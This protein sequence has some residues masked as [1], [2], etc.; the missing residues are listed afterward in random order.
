MSNS[1]RTKLVKVPACTTSA[2]TTWTQAVVEQIIIVLF[3]VFLSRT[4]AF[5]SIGRRRRS[6][7]N[8][9]FPETFPGKLQEIFFPAHNPT[10]MN[11][12]NDDG[13]DDQY[14]ELLL[15]LLHPFNGLFS[16]TTWVSRYQKGKTSLD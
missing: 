2:Y 14:E 11:E 12:M 16:R 6:T 3:F 15:L 10:F 7:N 8:G 9:Q 1:G 5:A 4:S 13:D